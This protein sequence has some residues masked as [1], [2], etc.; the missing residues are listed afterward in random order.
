VEERAPGKYGSGVRHRR[1]SES[2][3]VIDRGSALRA[4]DHEINLVV[5]VVV[6]EGDPRSGFRLHTGES[7]FVLFE[8]RGEETA[9]PSQRRGVKHEIGERVA[10]QIEEAGPG[11]P[12][13]SQRFERKSCQGPGEIRSQPCRDT[14]ENGFGPGEKGG[15]GGMRSFGNEAPGFAIQSPRQPSARWD[16][17]PLRDGKGFLFRKTAHRE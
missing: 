1:R 15:K 8:T 17:R 12:F 3:C 7:F 10:V 13:P 6:H 11:I 14:A 5:V 9:N 16:L 4:H 2:G